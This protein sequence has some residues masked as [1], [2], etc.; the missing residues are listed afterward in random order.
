MTKKQAWG[1]IAQ[2]SEKDARRVT[3]AEARGKSPTWARGLCTLLHELR[4]VKQL[5]SQ[6]R[7]REM[8]KD[9][10][11]MFGSHLQSSHWWPTTMAPTFDNI[12]RGYFTFTERA[13]VTG[14]D[15]RADFWGRVFAAWLM[16]HTTDGRR[17]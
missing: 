17:G 6:E 14:K 4:T 8:R 15:L 12:E 11:K 7:E 2:E 1:V 16:Y 13:P 10:R 9:M 3:R 5:I